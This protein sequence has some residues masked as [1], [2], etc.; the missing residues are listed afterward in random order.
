LVVDVEQIAKR[1]KCSARQVNM[2]ISLAFLA[3]YLVRAAVEAACPAALVSSA[4]AILR[5]NGAANRAADTQIFIFSIC[6]DD[7]QRVVGSLV[8]G[9]AATKRLAHGA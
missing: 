6:L 7:R 5:R 3:P 9:S 8:L 2:T 4:F 1:Q